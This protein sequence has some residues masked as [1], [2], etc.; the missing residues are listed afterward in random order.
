M[1]TNKAVHTPTPRTAE[2][3]PAV[4]LTPEQQLRRL[5]AT[6]LLWEDNFYLD[7][8]AAAEL[9]AEL[10][11]RVSPE[12][13][14]AVAYE[15][16]TKQKLRH[17]PL[18]I[19]R[20]MARLPRHKHLVD[21]LLPDVIQ[22]ADEL[23]EFVAL[24]WKDG[25]QP[26]SKKVKTGLARA[27]QRFDEYA[28]AKYDRDGAVR[29]RDVL[30]L[31]HA[32]P[33]DEAQAALWQRLV[34][35][36]LATPDTWEVALSA[37]ADKRA[38]FERLMAER[39][40]LA[41]AFLRNLRNM[42][43][44]GV[45]HETLRAY[46][47]TLDVTRV[48]PFRFIA[49]AR[50]VPALEPLLEPLMLRAVAG[51]SKLPGRTLVLV[52]V[53]GSMS[54]TVSARADLTRLDAACGVAML[55]RELCDDCRVFTF[56][57]DAK[58]V[59]PRRGFALRDAIVGSQP[60]ASTYLGRAVSALNVYEHDR[61]VVFTDEQSH[62]RVPHPV[63]APQRAYLINVAANRN[64]VGYGAWHHIDGWSEAVIDY[65]Q[66]TERDAEAV[67]LRSHAADAAA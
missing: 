34:E 56:S 45:P 43:E 14:A 59:A 48:L 29:L 22:R 2:G 32:K 54:I 40:L 46:A 62:D 55:L 63:V 66:E 20:E 1:K 52:D 47:E 27:F 65:L 12:F 58:E 13:A 49:A 10:V 24:Y 8:K 67:S 15:A 23:A 53:S 60:H 19:V 6:C 4:R 26:L 64:G 33:R 25:R 61:L 5:A 18:W 31:C 36:R 28:L 44:A 9:V 11:G 17:M 57:D 51:R 41:L 21:R 42:V 16:R 37:G 3:A 50:A 30:F 35:G 38:A 39:K 7:G